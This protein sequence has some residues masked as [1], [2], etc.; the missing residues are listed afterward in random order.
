MNLGL[1]YLYGVKGPSGKNQP[2]SCQNLL[3]L[4]YRF[5]FEGKNYLTKLNLFDII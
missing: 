3:V 1:W 4:I 2:K 5:S